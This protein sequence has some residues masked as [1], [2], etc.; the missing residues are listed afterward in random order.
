M[1]RK[2]N[3]ELNELGS[4]GDPVCRTS[5]RSHAYRWAT[6]SRPYAL[7]VVL[8]LSALVF[9]GYKSRPWSIRD[10]ETYPSRLMSEKV[11]IAIEPLFLDS[12]A[13]KVFDRDDVVS[14]GIM[15]IAVAIFNGNDFP[16]AVEADSIELSLGEEKLRTLAPGEVVPRL[17]QKK[18]GRKVWIPNP[19]PR[20]PSAVGP[21]AEALEDLDH[22][23]L[24]TK[25]VAPGS[26]GGGFIYMHVGDR[27]DLRDALA[28]SQIYIPDVYRQD[29]GDKLIYFE[30]DLKPAIVAAPKK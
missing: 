15:P 22:K 21:D 19:V 23:F 28:T 11:T 18:E 7:A 24:G 17:F 2:R 4:G 10:A 29:T 16:V 6:A 14:R 12:L 13:A 25:I 8:F 9:S 1:Q 5:W 30:I 27:K 26:K 3:Q 20:I